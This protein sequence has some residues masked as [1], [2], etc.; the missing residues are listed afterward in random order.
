MKI[1][2]EYESSWRNS[3][4]SGSNDERSKDRKYI[5]SFTALKKP[6]NQRHTPITKNTVMGILNRLIGDRRKLYQ[7]R[8]DPCYYFKEIEAV[9]TDEHIND[10]SIVNN[11]LIYIRN[12]W[13]VT[14]KNKYKGLIDDQHVAFNSAYSR[15]LWSVPFMSFDQVLDF[16]ITGQVDLADDLPEV[17][18]PLLVADQ[19]NLLNSLKDE[20][21]TSKG[22][23]A[24]SILKEEFDEIEY[25]FT[26]KNKFRLIAFWCSA[27]YLMLNKLQ[28]V[29][30]LTS[31]LSSR[32][33]LSGISKRTYTHAEFLATYTGGKKMVY[34]NPY[35]IVKREKGAGEEIIK[36]TTASGLLTVELP[37]NVEKAI[38]LK[39]LIEAA[40]VGPFYMGKKGLA[41]VKSIIIGDEP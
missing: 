10:Q 28:Q 19:F 32:G 38:E 35:M 1:L 21:L 31:I 40:G 22:Q 30:D 41:H 26:S 39:N 29:H 8:E 14:D 20:D 36:M 3:V 5:A 4:L 23:A 16:I 15:Y 18:D 33:L 34:G 17:F 2:I 13:G 25:S 11:E 7:S 12:I 24:L 9:L 6:E 27:M 37:I